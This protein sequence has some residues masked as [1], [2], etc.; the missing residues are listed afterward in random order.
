MGPRESE[1]EASEQGGRSGVI[2]G[3]DSPREKSIPPVED[4]LPSRLGVVVGELL[5]D[6]R[7]RVVD[8]V[9]MRVERLGSSS[10]LEAELIAQSVSL[11]G[12][13][14]QSLLRRWRVEVRLVR[15]PRVPEEVEGCSGSSS[16]VGDRRYSDFM[17][18]EAL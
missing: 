6:L 11:S 1:Q 3:D 15:A 10:E 2:C 8:R 4:E 13:K 14:L 18:S 12:E 5:S 7:L 9:V 17:K 16:G